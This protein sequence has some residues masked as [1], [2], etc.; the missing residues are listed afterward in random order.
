M[1]LSSSLW[2]L[3]L[4]LLLLIFHFLIH[5]MAAAKECMNITRGFLISFPFFV[6]F[7]F[8]FVYVRLSAHSCDQIFMS[9]NREEYEKSGQFSIQTEPASQRY[10]DDDFVIYNGMKSKLLN[11]ETIFLLPT[12]AIVIALP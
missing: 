1:C 8:A 10:G 12:V 4:L 9:S 2:F 11:Y 5:Q 3:L 6:H 7:F